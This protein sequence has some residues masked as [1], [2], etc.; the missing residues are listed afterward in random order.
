M[1][2]QM[3]SIVDSRPQITP[4]APRE[5]APV[6]PVGAALTQSDPTA[7]SPTPRLASTQSTFVVSLLVDQDTN[8]L[9]MEWSDR[10][11][12]QIIAEIPVKTAAKVG[13]EIN[14]PAP[15]SEHVNLQI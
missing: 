11:S 12:G 6:S 1:S 13:G 10:A 5:P 15:S 14:V 8:R 7:I 2:A 9:I 4:I 3:V